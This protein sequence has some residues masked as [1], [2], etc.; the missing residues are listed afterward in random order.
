MGQVGRPR[1]PGVGAGSNG[2]TARIGFQVSP[3][4]YEAARRQAEREG[5]S[6]AAWIRALMQDAVKEDQ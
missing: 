1:L 4:L 2:V 6:L 5:V 3:Q